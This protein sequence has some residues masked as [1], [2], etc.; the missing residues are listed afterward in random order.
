MKSSGCG[1]RNHRPKPIPAAARRRR[2]ASPSCRNSSESSRPKSQNS[3]KALSE[4]SSSRSPSTTTTSPSGS[5]PDSPSTSTNKSRLAHGIVSQSGLLSFYLLHEICWLLFILFTVENHTCRGSKGNAE[6][7]AD[8][9]S[10]HTV[11]H[12]HK[13]KAPKNRHRNSNQQHDDYRC[14]SF[15]V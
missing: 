3:T 11:K 4:S 10:C 15:H 8:S 5:N 7:N 6:A 9:D 12:I 14:L 2:S 13:N 1:S